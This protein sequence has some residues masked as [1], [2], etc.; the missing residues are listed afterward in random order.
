MAKLEREGES[1]VPTL[2]QFTNQDIPEAYAHQIRDF[3]RIHW[4]DVFQY[5]VHAPP[6]P[7][8]SHPVYF[9]L[10]DGP[11]LFSHAAVVTQTVECTGQTYSCGGLGSVFTYPAF[12]KRGYGHQVV[13]AAAEYLTTSTF[14]LS[15]LWTDADKQAFY[16]RSGWEHR[17]A[18][19]TYYGDKAAPEL[20]DAFTM[21]RMTSDRAKQHRA[22]F[23][24]APVYIGQYG[25]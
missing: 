11:A 21:I 8:A 25:W 12:R 24:S 6:M 3:I 23:E 1:V 19:R 14:D 15:L 18:L 5:D 17:P 20:Y 4:F 10:V 22:D 2:C 7:D 13:Q 16:E 9:V